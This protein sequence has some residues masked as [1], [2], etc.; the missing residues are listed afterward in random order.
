M[1]DSSVRPEVVVLITKVD[2][3]RRDD[4]TRP[5]HRDGRPFTPAEHALLVTCTPEERAAA[6]AQ[7]RR[8]AEWQRELDEMQDAF[9][10]LLMKYFA[11]LPKGFTVSDAVALMTDEDYAEFERLAEIVTAEDTLEFLAL[12]GKN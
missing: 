11:E 12:Y 2:F 8:A 7:I 10:E 1:P 4:P 9:V 5:Y 6:K 3:S